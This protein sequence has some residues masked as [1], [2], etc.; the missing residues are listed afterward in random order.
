LQ[1]ASVGFDSLEQPAQRAALFEIQIDSSMLTTAHTVEVIGE[2]HQRVR[3]L[4]RSLNPNQNRLAKTW[5][6]LRAW[7]RKCGDHLA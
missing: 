2:E 1:R 6:A 7:V 5:L 3:S 4:M